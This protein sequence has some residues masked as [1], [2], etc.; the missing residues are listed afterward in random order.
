MPVSLQAICACSP[1]WQ[2]GTTGCLQLPSGVATWHDW[3]FAAAVWRAVR[4]PARAAAAQQPPPY[5]ALLPRR[6]DL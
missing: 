6:L 4:G 3:L 5:P 1:V 2:H